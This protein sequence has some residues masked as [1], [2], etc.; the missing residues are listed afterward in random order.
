MVRLSENT[1]IFHYVA[2]IAPWL[3]SGSATGFVAL[4]ATVYTTYRVHVY[5][6][7]YC[8]WVVNFPEI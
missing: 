4:T 2:G 1:Y 5:R 7:W 3:P 8:N 6:Y